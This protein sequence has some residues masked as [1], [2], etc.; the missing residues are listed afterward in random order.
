MGILNKELFNEEELQNTRIRYELLI[1]WFNKIN[2]DEQGIV[3]QL[4]YLDY[5]QK[6]KGTL[7]IEEWLEFLSDY[8]VSMLLDKVML[9]NM[10][11]NVNKILSSDNKSVAASQKLSSALTFLSKYFDEAMGRESVVYIYTSVPLTKDEE[12][13]RNAKTLVVRP[14]KNPHNPM[15]GSSDHGV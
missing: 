13:A 12:F 8:R 7:T 9:I 1:Y 3:D 5:H 6:S 10:R 2:E 4:T 15:K 14:K 11:S